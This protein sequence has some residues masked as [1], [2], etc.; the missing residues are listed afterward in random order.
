VLDADERRVLRAMLN[1][2]AEGPPDDPKAVGS[3]M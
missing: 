1:R 3:C 2:L